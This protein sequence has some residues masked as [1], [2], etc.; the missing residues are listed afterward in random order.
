MLLL[1]TSSHPRHTH[2]GTKYTRPLLTRPSGQAFGVM[3]GIIRL[4]KGGDRPLRAEVVASFLGIK[5]YFTFQGCVYQTEGGAH[6]RASL[7][8]E[9][10]RS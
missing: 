1:S 8:V 5:M 2:S 10:R 6:R 9:L 7:R 3:L 4:R